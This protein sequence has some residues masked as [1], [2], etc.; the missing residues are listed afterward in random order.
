MSAFIYVILN[1]IANTYIISIAVPNNGPVILHEMTAI[2]QW[3]VEV[4][5]YQYQ[6]GGEQLNLAAADD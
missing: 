3:G 1:F 6:H 4:P 2:C 5:A